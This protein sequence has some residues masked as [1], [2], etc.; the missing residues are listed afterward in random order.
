MQSIEL[1]LKHL[2]LRPDRPTAELFRF[3]IFDGSSRVVI[4]A[5]SEEDARC[6]CRQMSW[7]FI[8]VCEG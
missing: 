1:S 2:G 7:E 5:Q 4:E 3:Q 6:L 8:C